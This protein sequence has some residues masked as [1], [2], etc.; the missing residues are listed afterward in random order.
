M[1]ICGEYLAWAMNSFARCWRWRPFGTDKDMASWVIGEKKDH[2]DTKMGWTVFEFLVIVIAFIAY[3][4]GG[5]VHIMD[6]RGKD[7]GPN[8][9][10]YY[11][12]SRKPWYD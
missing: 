8:V 12:T 1:T 4:M 3:L 11:A 10:Q 6:P 7:T 9:N 2:E 5:C